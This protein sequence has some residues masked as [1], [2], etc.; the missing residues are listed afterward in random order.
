MSDTIPV[1]VSADYAR[2][3]YV[4][5]PFATIDGS[6]SEPY[7]MR[8]VTRAAANR[9][10]AATVRARLSR[11][12][13]L[14]TMVETVPEYYYRVA[15]NDFLRRMSDDPSLDMMALNIP[16]DI[17]RLGRI[18][19]T[20]AELSEL[21][22]AVDLPAT[23]AGWFTRELQRTDIEM[24]ESGLVTPDE[25]AAVREAFVSDPHGAFDRYFG[26]PAEPASASE[27]DAV[28]HE[29]YMRQVGQ[30]VDMEKDEET[31]ESSPALVENIPNGPEADEEP[32]D[33]DADMREYLLAL[34]REHLSPVL[35]R[36][37]AGY[38][39]YGESLAAQE[40]KVTKAPRKTLAAILRLMNARWG[41]VTVIYDSFSAWP[42][43]DQQTKMEILSSMTELRW[44]I[45]DA[46]VMVVATMKGEA[47]ELEEQFAAAEQVDWSM[48][49]LSAMYGGDTTVDLAR[50]QSWLDAASM[51][52]ASPVRADGPEFVALAAAAGGDITVLSAMAEAAFRDAATRGVDALDETAV[53]AGLA[54]K[55]GAVG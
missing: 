36:A 7:W 6:G 31:I 53:A 28:V 52:A 50:V 17:M 21:I 16:L 4:A 33:P 12:P 14:V 40:M 35:A 42:I 8:L 30:P 9:L 38:A 27:L 1:P 23:V 24:P 39:R 15:Q 10:L 34:A 22:V 26:V 55:S 20:I 46:G 47:P 32:A 3:G 48:P 44:I 13:V 2:L 43:L 19:G 11:K 29:A 45:A 49:E 41:S 18:R 51:D 54:T 25:V 5:N 37:I